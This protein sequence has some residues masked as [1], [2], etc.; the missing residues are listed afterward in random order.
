MRSGLKQRQR[1]FISNIITYYNK[2]HLKNVGPIR[3]CEP[4][5]HCH[6]PAR[7]RYCRTPA[8]AIAQAACDVHDDN[9]NDNDNAWQRGPLW[10]HGMGPTTQAVGWS[11][12]SVTLRVCPCS[13]RKTTWAVNT[14]LGTQ[15]LYGRTSAC[16]ELKGKRSEVKVT[17]LWSML[18]KNVGMH[19]MCNL[20]KYQY[21]KI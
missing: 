10:L 15:I 1:S 16:I 12:A 9:D 6:L 11:A 2:K 18:P 3:H 13:K 8:I 20:V 14:K 17:G 4:P 19:Y 21:K 7:C 5:L